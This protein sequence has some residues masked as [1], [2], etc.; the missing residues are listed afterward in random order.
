MR[1]LAWPSRN[2]ASIS[3]TV[4]IYAIFAQRKRAPTAS[5]ASETTIK[6]PERDKS[7][8]A[9]GSGGLPGQDDAKEVIRRAIPVVVD[10]EAVL[11]EEAHV[12]VFV[13]GSL[14]TTP[15]VPVREE[16]LALVQQEG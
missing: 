11:V 7:S 1:C 6:A 12:H 14:Q 13:A 4:L 10:E 9:L 16:P 3:K 8:R 15:V 5:L 2:R